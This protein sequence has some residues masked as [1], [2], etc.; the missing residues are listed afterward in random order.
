MVSHDNDLFTRSWSSTEELI[1]IALDTLKEG[2]LIH[3]QKGVEVPWKLLV[4]K[5][6]GIRVY[7]VFDIFNTDYDPAKGHLPER[8]NLPV[9]IVHFSRKGVHTRVAEPGLRQ[10]VNNETAE[11]HNLNGW[12]AVPPFVTD[13]TTTVPIYMNPRDISS[14]KP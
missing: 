14:P 8:N 1:P 3:Q 12:D 13:H 4:K 9:L 10:R 2:Q 5:N 11:A 6:W 7:I